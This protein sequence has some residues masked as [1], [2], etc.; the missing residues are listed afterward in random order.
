MNWLTS[1]CCFLKIDNVESVS[2]RLTNTAALF[3]KLG[4][5]PIQYEIEKRQLVSLKIILDRGNYD[6]FK[7]G[8]HE[9]FKY[10]TE[11]TR[12]IMSMNCGVSTVFL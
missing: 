9:R 6:P 3:L 8:C 1:R 7:M 4:I 11:T 5:L 12:Q 2:F 10:Q